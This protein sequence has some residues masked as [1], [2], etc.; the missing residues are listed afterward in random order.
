MSWCADM[1]WELGSSNIQPFIRS[2]FS[3]PQCLSPACTSEEREG[4]D[5]HISE[6]LLFTLTLVVVVVSCCISSCPEGTSALVR[7]QQP[8]EL[9]SF[10]M[11]LEL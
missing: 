7:L 3:L 2:G 1:S 6:S 8:L 5:L 10:E 11:I 9:M 4:K